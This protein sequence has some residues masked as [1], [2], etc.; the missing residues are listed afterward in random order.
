MSEVRLIVIGA[1]LGG[2]TAL[3]ALCAALPANYSAAVAVVQHVGGRRQ[4]SLA[5]LLGRRAVVPVVEVEDKLPL[6]PGV[7]H[8]APAGYHLLVDST[9]TFALSVDD[10]VNFSRPSIDVLFESAAETFRDRVTGVILTGSNADGARGVARVQAAGGGVLVQD[11]DEAEAP[12]M[13]R[14]AIQAV[15]R[16]GVWVA[17]LPDLIHAIATLAPETATGG[18][19]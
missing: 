7:V 18:R 19:A 8:V 17:K 3:E 11:P 1:S 5:S 4:S 12:R 10:P 15:G 13:P 6:R 14:A 16:E 9:E 2:V